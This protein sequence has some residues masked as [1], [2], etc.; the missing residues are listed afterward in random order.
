M[1]I[2]VQRP[3]CFLDIGISNVLGKKEKILAA[4]WY[5]KPCV[6]CLPRKHTWFI[7]FR[8]SFS[9]WGGLPVLNRTGQTGGWEE[10]EGTDSKLLN[11]SPLQ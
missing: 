11:P 4:F 5:F 8:S 9:L 7:F 6:V 2:K 1:G 3:R 10:S